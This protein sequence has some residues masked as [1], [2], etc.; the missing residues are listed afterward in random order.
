MTLS[1]T[2]TPSGHDVVLIQIE[3]NKKK[4]DDIKEKMMYKSIHSFLS[5]QDLLAIPSLSYIV[6]FTVVSF[7]VKQIEA[8]GQTNQGGSMT[9]AVII[10]RAK[11]NKKGTMFVLHYKWW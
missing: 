10:L 3:Y 11:N 7:T 4:C 8:T 6:L 1:D 5:W 9:G 2:I